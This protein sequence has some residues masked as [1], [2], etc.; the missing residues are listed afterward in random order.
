[1]RASTP[2][3]VQQRNHLKE[4]GGR[5][6]RLL[7]DAH[8]VRLRLDHPLRHRQR[9]VGRDPHGDASRTSAGSP[10]S[11]KRAA[12]QWMKGIK[13]RCLRRQGI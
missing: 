9:S 6:Q 5:K 12:M 4:H 1:M 3:A 7:H 10:L 2:S 8:V 13:H 11:E